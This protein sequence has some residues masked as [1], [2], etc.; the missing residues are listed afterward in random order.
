M[1][2]PQYPGW[3]QQQQWGA[4]SPQQGW[5]GPPA[6]P[7]PP[8]PRR[9]KVWLWL[10]PL[11]VLVVAAGVTV[12]IMLNSGDDEPQGT[13]ENKSGG[14]KEKPGEPTTKGWTVKDDRPPN[15]SG[16]AVWLVDDLLVFAR[17]GAVVAYGRADG[18]EKWR[19]EPPEGVFCAASD[20]EVDGV[21]ALAFG[22]G[23]VGDPHNVPCGTATLLDLSKGELGWQ[24]KFTAP[25]N[26]SPDNI[27]SG[28]ALEIVAG[29]VVIA[30]DQGMVGLDLADGKQV[31]AKDVQHKATG[32][33]GCQAYDMVAAEN[34]VVI[35]QSC[36]NQ[37]GVVTF[38]RI[39]P[40]TGETTQTADFES[41]DPAGRF[42]F[43]DFVSASPPVAWVSETETNSKLVMLAEDLQSGTGT[44]TGDPTAAA[45]GLSRDSMGFDR[46]GDSQ[47]YPMRLLI[48][49]DTAY[50]VTAPVQDAENTLVALD[51]TTGEQ[52]WAEP[53]AGARVLQPIAV[54]DGKLV[55]AGGPVGRDGPMHLIKVNPEDGSVDSDEEFAVSDPDGGGPLAESF[56]FFWAD[57]RVYAVR[58]KSN[59]HD[60]DAFSFGG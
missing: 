57:D 6:P 55:V 19:V 33:L 12:P 46:P 39:D 7:P 45:A 28:A 38:S 41:S 30:Q 49:G 17:E 27:R 48:D 10:A 21:V 50:G 26:V 56:R 1:G 42:E 9:G 8:P 52:K 40:A 22:P 47:H 11:L 20:R 2:S 29:M 13:A 53:V 60:I 25:Q 3:Q 58:G 54:D 59:E 32:E 16:L 24:G 44:P 43:P 23:M 14:E 4:P 34:G 37:T 5:Y 31:W 51:L 36:L 18:A 15:E 35:G